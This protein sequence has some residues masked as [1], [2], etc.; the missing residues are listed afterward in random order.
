[1][2][3][4]ERR[5]IHRAHIRTELTE[6]VE[7]SLHCQLKDKIERL[8]ESVGDQEGLS[9]VDKGKREE[10][11]ACVFNSHLRE[12]MALGSSANLTLLDF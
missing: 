6:N 4:R 2:S 3:H 8:P 12:R 11:K 10:V 1:M 5:D 7:L 9:E